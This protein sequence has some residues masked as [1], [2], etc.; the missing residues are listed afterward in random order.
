MP[1]STFITVQALSPF[2]RPDQGSGFLVHYHC[3]IDG[4]STTNPKSTIQGSI[5]SRATDWSWSTTRLSHHGK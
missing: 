5:Q 3:S 2:P 1:V 4:M